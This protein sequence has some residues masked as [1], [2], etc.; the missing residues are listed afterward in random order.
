[1]REAQQRRRRLLLV[2]AA[3]PSPPLQPLS[4]VTHF[5]MLRAAQHCLRTDPARPGFLPV[6]QFVSEPEFVFVS[7][8]VFVSV[9][10]SPYS[11]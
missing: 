4:A 5:V 3:L 6:L 10:V 11:M 8:I 1:M 2:V 9:F 7:V